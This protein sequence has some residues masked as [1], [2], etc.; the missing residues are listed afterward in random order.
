MA[1]CKNRRAVCQQQLSALLQN[2]ADFEDYC[3]NSHGKYCDMQNSFIDSYKR[4]FIFSHQAFT[5]YAR[6]AC[7][8][9]KTKPSQCYCGSEF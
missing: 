4:L 6:G 5:N 9:T 8:Q 1:N 3:N 2:V 7:S